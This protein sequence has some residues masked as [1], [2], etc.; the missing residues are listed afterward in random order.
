MR[1]AAPPRGPQSPSPP[2]RGS[3]C[4]A[5]RAPVGPAAPPPAPQPGP[6]PA[7]PG[8]P[9][10]AGSRTARGEDQGWGSHLGAVLS[11]ALAPKGRTGSPNTDH[12]HLLQVTV[13]PVS[14]G[15]P[16]HEA[17]LWGRPWRPGLNPLNLF[18]SQV[19]LVSEAPSGVCPDDGQ[20]P[21]RAVASRCPAPGAPWAPPGP[22]VLQ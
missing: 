18:L 16:P 4:M 12:K 15:D 10:A 1:A 17:V 14:P 2:P 22:S 3:G 11:G 9:A 5:G 20:G 21:R 6:G 13:C 19:V 7:V 8:A